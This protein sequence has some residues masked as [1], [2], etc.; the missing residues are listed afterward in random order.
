[1]TPKKFRTIANRTLKHIWPFLY[2]QLSPQDVTVL[3][4]TP[5]ACRHFELRILHALAQA[6]LTKQELRNFFRRHASQLD[7]HTGEPR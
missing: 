2:A 4:D 6:L 3:H 7:P 5:A 1:M